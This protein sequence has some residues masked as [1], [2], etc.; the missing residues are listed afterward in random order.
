[1]AYYFEYDLTNFYLAW[2][3]IVINTGQGSNGFSVTGN[4]FQWSE[5]SGFGG[6]FGKTL[7][8]LFSLQKAILF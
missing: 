3:P 7:A 8:F 5:A 2:D 4:K 1:M 6:W